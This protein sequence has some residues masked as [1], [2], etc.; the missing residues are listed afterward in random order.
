MIKNTFNQI[1]DDTKIYTISKYLPFSEHHELHYITAI[2]MFIDKPILGHGPKLFR[3]KCAL[4]KYFIENGC[5]THPHNTYIQLLSETGFIGFIFIFT[6]FIY[7]LYFF[8]KMFL[9]NKI[10]NKYDSIIYLPV[11]LSLFPFFPT[12]SFFNNW[13]NVLYY[14]PI[15]IMI[16][17]LKELSKNKTE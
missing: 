17:K 11:L 15:G 4:D 1:T 14:F 6:I 9:F 12:G 3:K 13:L 8:F 10:T 2:K 16:W 5:S 7:F